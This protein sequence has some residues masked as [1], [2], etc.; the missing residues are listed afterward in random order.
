MAE[1]SDEVPLSEVQRWLR[2][3]D[4]LK[5]ESKDVIATN[6]EQTI[7][8]TAQQEIQNL[9]Q[10][11]HVLDLQVIN[12]D[13][14]INLT[15]MNRMSV[16]EAD[17]R[18][19]DEIIQFFEKLHPLGDQ[20]ENYVHF[21]RLLRSNSSYLARA[22]MS[23][24]FN[25]MAPIIKVIVH[26]LFG[27][28]FQAREELLV[29]TFIKAILEEHIQHIT[30]LDQL[31][32]QNTFVSK[33]L[34]AYT[35]RSGGKTYL[36]T[37]FRSLLMETVLDK[38]LDLELDPLKI[39]RKLKLDFDEEEA[40]AKNS[41]IAAI[42]AEHVARLSDISQ[43]FLR[44]VESTLHA[45]PFG[46]RWVAK[47]L[48]IACVTRFPDISDT[49][50]NI[51]LG[52]FI[53]L[54]FITPCIATLE[55]IRIE[56]LKITDQAQRNLV[57]IGKTLQG[58]A[59]AVGFGRKEAFMAP[60][61]DFIQAQ[62]EQLTAYF[63][64]LVKVGDPSEFLMVSSTRRSNCTNV[65]HI[66][67]NELFSLHK[68]LIKYRAQA[69]SG[70]D[71]PMCILLDRL[72]PVSANRPVKEN[73]ILALDVS[74][75]QTQQQLDE[76]GDRR[77]KDALKVAIRDAL[78]CTPVLTETPQDQQRQP[79]TG[80]TLTVINHQRKTITLGKLRVAEGDLLPG[81]PL[82]RQTR[83]MSVQSRTSDI[84]SNSLADMNLDQTLPSS[85]IVVSPRSTAVSP[86]SP[87]SAEM[88]TPLSPKLR[89][90]M[91]RRLSVL[92]LDEAASVQDSLS[93]LLFAHR[94]AAP[95]V[96][97][98]AIALL[99]GHDEAALLDEMEHDLH[100]RN[101]Y[102]ANLQR[103]LSEAQALTE[104]LRVRVKDLRDEKLIFSQ[105][106]D[107]ITTKTF[108]ASAAASQKAPR[109][110]SLGEATPMIGPFKFTYKQLLKEQVA[111]DVEDPSCRKVKLQI[112]STVPGTVTMQMKL[113]GKPLPTVEIR[114]QD[115]M[116]Q[117]FSK[118]KISYNRV[119]FSGERLLAFLNKHLTN[120]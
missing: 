41:Q 86:T 61:N 30:Q 102:R 70:P 56:G 23:L 28:R 37:T 32:R 69:T 49:Q 99:S 51:I 58:L 78:T 95:D 36:N 11:H 6:K 54:R 105:Y 66:R 114:M 91:Q 5:S 80:D 101:V 48:L 90:S 21:A 7:L 31:I 10:T 35:W 60:M 72:G 25:D 83:A 38:A 73:L 4:L 81:S 67:P 77:F 110:A 89:A 100:L 1:P 33:L 74:D 97:D 22:V 62:R 9:L 45:L 40:A 8:Q 88:T 39:A 116:D 75:T 13:R 52:G 118:S 85:P 44:L 55:A 108:E 18:I 3:Q 65:I 104:E 113:N 12:L 117:S 106:L 59:N 98:T 93:N 57:L 71:D 96:V 24:S 42:I 68:L 50:Q 111:V 87:R 92:A 94:Q 2:L 112:S 63:T 16:Q 103:D 82:S 43:K 17:I 29:L 120:K 64:E 14:K 76:Q 34:G 15:I 27:E 119:I 115:L 107:N 19:E 47:Q 109:R 53:F 84:S 79:V 46:I 20:T 26:S